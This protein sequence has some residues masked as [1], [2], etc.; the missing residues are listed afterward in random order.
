MNQ[1]I[2]R[3]EKKSCFFSPHIFFAI[4]N[5][6]SVL[7]MDLE[8]R[9]TLCKEYYQSPVYLPCSHSLC[10][11]CAL[12]SVRTTNTNDD[13]NSSMNISFASDLDKLSLTSDN[14]S[15]IS[16]TSRPSSLLLPPA[17]PELSLIS[18]EST[19]RTIYSTY[20]QCSVCSKIID[21]DTSGVRSLPKNDL[22]INII[23]GYQREQAFEQYTPKCQSCRSSKEQ[24]ITS[25]CEQREIGYCD[26][27]RELY[28]PMRG[29]HSKYD[30]INANEQIFNHNKNTFCSNHLN[31]LASFYCLHCRIQCCQLCSKH[32]SHQ[33]IPIH[34]ATKMLKVNSFDYCR[35]KF[36]YFYYITST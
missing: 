3:N 26:E 32:T 35:I 19:H 15:G 20:L 14:D 5:H 9:C 16:S 31:R 7:S 8:L 27:C 24:S 33:M 29:L 18:I 25:V 1:T 17:L 2:Y 22:L 34:Q 28:H 21:M 30:L 4:L 12:V 11:N 10:C 36:L 6:L 23:N 13:H